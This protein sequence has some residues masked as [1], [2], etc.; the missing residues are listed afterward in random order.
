VIVYRGTSTEVLH[1]LAPYVADFLGG[2]HVG[3]A[4]VTGDGYADI[5][6]GAGAPAGPHVRVFDG[7]SG[8]AVHS[9]L[10]GV[11]DVA[12]GVRVAGG[13]VNGDGRADII[14]GLGPGGAPL[15]RVFDGVT[16]TPIS[17]WLAYDP[18][19]TGGVFVSTAVPENRMVVETPPES[20]A[21]G[22]SFTLRGWA[23]QEGAR[24]GTGVDA[25]HVWAY[26]A[27]GG[28]P[29]FVGAGTL[30]DARPDIGA[31]F[32]ERFADAGFHLDVTG[33]ADGRYTL[34]VFGR[35]ATSR[36]FNVRRTILVTVRR[37]TVDVRLHIDIP[38]AG[39]VGPNFRVAGWA[40]NLG[41][42][43]NHGIEAIHAWAY[44]QNGTPPF[45]LGSATLGG[46]RPDVAAAMGAQFGTSGFSL[47]VTGLA[48]G[49]YLLA[50]FPKALGHPF[51]W[52]E[53]LTV[54]VAAPERR[55]WTVIDIPT[56]GILP[57]GAFRV[58]GWAALEGGTAPDI[59][60]IHVW[61]Y[62]VGG[63]EPVFLGLPTLGGTR[64][65]VAA[66]LGHA[67]YSTSGFNLATTLPPG[68]WDLAVFVSPVGSDGFADARVVR[69]TIPGG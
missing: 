15:V 65:D 69:I 24:S 14:T 18:A 30:G 20:A 56:A 43:S 47:N 7:R 9:F 34:V 66:F 5:L 33:L 19:F 54:T 59:A 62:P 22:D 16:L 48:P 41:A 32:G 23:F 37:P 3:A 11:A 60:T 57:G 53:A 63:G 26:P 12:T 13:D 38:L 10:A 28:A 35:S 4:D 29:L 25:I 39:T 8:A 68:T 36:T 61:A 45:F 51:R 44:P 21:L 6:T 64:P 49:S 27:E 55:L 52:A 31:I 1:T 17:E 40:L 42:I 50:L 67:G 2:V 58:A 46:A